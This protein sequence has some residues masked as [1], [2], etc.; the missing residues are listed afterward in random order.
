MTKEERV[1]ASELLEMITGE[2]YRYSEYPSCIKLRLGRGYSSLIQDDDPD[3]L[4]NEY[5]VKTIKISDQRALER[6][7]EWLV[8]TEAKLKEVKQ[9][10][11]IVLGISKADYDVLNAIERK[12]KYG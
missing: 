1:K 10:R 8:D 6:M 5:G 12:I 4:F 2:G 3:V 11:A 9:F 7:Y